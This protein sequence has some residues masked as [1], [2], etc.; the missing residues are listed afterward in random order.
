YDWLLDT[1]NTDHHPQQIEFSRLNLDYTIMSKRK[2]H[3]LVAEGKV[4]GWDDPRMPTISGLRRRGYT[5][6]AIREFCQRI[7]VTRH[8]NIIEM[9]VLESCIRED[10]EAA[11]RVLGV[12][13]PLKLVI[14]NYPAG[15]VEQLTAQNHPQRP[16][17]GSRDLP[18]S[19]ELYVE[20]DDFMEEPPKKF[21]RLGPGREVRL[22][23]GYY[24]TCTDVIKDAAGEV[25]E[26]HCTYDP[27]TRGGSSPDGRKVKGTIHWVSAA[28]ALDAEVR[29]YDRL[30]NEPNPAAAGDDFLQL[31]NP[32]SLRVM[33]NAKLEPGL[34]E[35]KT[36]IGYQ[37]ERLGYFCVDK[38]AA[39][40]PVFN[41]TVTLRDS[42]AK[43]KR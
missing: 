30:F 14:T 34:A 3:T 10:L 43:M 16:E 18:F 40:Q 22:R 1:L 38:A 4:S 15:Q 31:L 9:G 26:I 42:W 17:M 35:A 28:H 32:D 12:V 29:L 37:F 21:F 33:G 19:G 8:D 39:G 13:N 23:Y 24:V 6:A 20:R 25:I 41:R 36:G 2:L 27:A 5:A 11:P 7:G